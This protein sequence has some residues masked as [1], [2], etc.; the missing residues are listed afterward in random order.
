MVW[1]QF[2]AAAYL[3]PLSLSPFLLPLA[4]SFPP[5]LSHPCGAEVTLDGFKSLHN[6]QIL[7]LTV[8]S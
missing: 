8:Y 6:S 4:S 3:S 7:E 1:L 2:F 5:A